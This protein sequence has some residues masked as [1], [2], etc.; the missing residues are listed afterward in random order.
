M[1]RRYSF[2]KVSTYLRCPRL[3]RFRYVDKAEREHL[4]LALP[5]GS[6]MHDA[7]QWDVSERQN[8][9]E[10]TEEE[11][12]AVFTELLEARV[13]ISACPVVGDIPEAIETAKR[14][15]EAYCAW[16]R[17]QDVSL[18]E[19]EHMANISHELSLEGRV[20]FVRDTAESVELVELKTSARAWSPAQAEYSLQAAAY[21]LLSGI[22]QV[23]YI[24]LTKTKA[25]KVQELVTLCD[26]NRTDQLRDTIAE[27]D[28][29]VQAGAFPRN[30]SP[31]TCGGCEF[32][33]RCLNSSQPATRSESVFAGI[34][35]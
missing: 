23:R 7:V 11:I 15:I 20:D 1:R 26:Q 24:I 9:R 31:M 4:S 12:Y 16:G 30:A 22:S 32:R 8:G 5:M 2:S 18:I 33:N 28:T 13:E 3:F 29:A 17:I 35:N 27:V 34:I 6:A 25:P 21:S 14:M 10:P 19:G